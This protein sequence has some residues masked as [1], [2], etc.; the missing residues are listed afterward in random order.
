MPQTAVLFPG[1]GAQTVGMGRDV[2]EKSRAGRA[3]FE[4]A[5]RALGFSLSQTVGHAVEGLGQLTQLVLRMCFHPLGEITG[6]N[7]ACGDSQPAN[8]GCDLKEKQTTQR[9]GDGAGHQH[10]QQDRAIDSTEEFPGRSRG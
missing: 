7:T 5:D 9:Q 4:L 3:V 6:S 1:Q 10:C 2:F 8:G